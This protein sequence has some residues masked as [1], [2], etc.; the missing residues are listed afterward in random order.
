MNRQKFG[1]P[2]W[3]S[4]VIIWSHIAMEW[5]I[6]QTL[7]CVAERFSVHLIQY[8]IKPPEYLVDDSSVRANASIHSWFISYCSL[9]ISYG[10]VWLDVEWKRTDSHCAYTIIIEVE[11]V[12]FGYFSMPQMV[13]TREPL[14][15]TFNAIFKCTFFAQ[16][17]LIRSKM[18]A[19]G[20][21]DVD[22]ACKWGR[23]INKSPVINQ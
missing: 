13:W 7:H 21:D 3:S 18:Y 22:V 9:S 5:N 15:L 10:L 17:A 14:A 4:S 19:N 2:S 8:S 6:S 1:T 20:N 12:A 23:K 11:N 16:T